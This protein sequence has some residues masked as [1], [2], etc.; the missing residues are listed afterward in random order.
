VEF[1][2]NTVSEQNNKVAVYRALLESS[3]GRNITV[4]KPLNYGSVPVFLM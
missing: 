4:R 1:K 3:F 2:L